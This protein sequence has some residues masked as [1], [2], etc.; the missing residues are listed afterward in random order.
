MYVISVYI[1]KH[2]TT[3]VRIVQLVIGIGNVNAFIHNNNSAMQVTDV[4]VY[5]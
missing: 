5:L 4:S 2:D 1:I 3:H